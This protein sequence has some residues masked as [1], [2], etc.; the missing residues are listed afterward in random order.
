MY[1]FIIGLKNNAQ[2]IFVRIQ[3][4]G[5]KYQMSFSYNLLNYAS[6][7]RRLAHHKDR[8]NSILLKKWFPFKD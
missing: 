1:S 6:N 3:L 2:F 7:N 5:D 4:P 8:D